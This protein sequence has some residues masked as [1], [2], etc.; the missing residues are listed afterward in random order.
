MVEKKMMPINL[1]LNQLNYVEMGYG[2]PSTV[3]L[4]MFRGT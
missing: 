4:A 2:I 3:T 1:F